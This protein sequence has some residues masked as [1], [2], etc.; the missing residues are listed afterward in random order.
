MQKSQSDSRRSLPYQLL[1]QNHHITTWRLGTNIFTSA[2]PATLTLHPCRHPSDLISVTMSSVCAGPG[3]TLV[4]TSSSSLAHWVGFLTPRYRLRPP[5]FRVHRSLPICSLASSL[6]KGRERPGMKHQTSY[7]A[8]RR[9][10]G[11]WKRGELGGVSELGLRVEGPDPIS[12]PVSMEV[13]EL[14]GRC[15][16]MI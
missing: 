10:C 7:C 3:A 11:I 12:R 15:L 5:R 9:W 4:T 1:L 14:G 13:W 6:R 16:A 2:T 8:S